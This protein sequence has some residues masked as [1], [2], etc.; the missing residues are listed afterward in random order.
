MMIVKSIASV[1]KLSRAWLLYLTEE[2][3]E[4][5]R[6]LGRYAILSVDLIGNPGR[7]AVFFA[8]GRSPQMSIHCCGLWGAVVVIHTG[9][10]TS[11]PSKRAA[12]WLSVVDGFFSVVL[13][14]HSVSVMIK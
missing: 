13:F 14:S 10:F 2:L 7:A 9:E 4:S 5:A 3:K 8:V 1:T 6:P 11:S 12:E